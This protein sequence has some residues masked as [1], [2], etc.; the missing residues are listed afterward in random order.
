MTMVHEGSVT[1]CVLA[2]STALIA[3]F[4]GPLRDKLRMIGGQSEEWNDDGSEYAPMY[5]DHADA[6]SGATAECLVCL[7]EAECGGGRCPAFSCHGPSASPSDV[8]VSPCTV[9]RAL[10]LLEDMLPADAPPDSPEFLGPGVSLA[11]TAEHKTVQ[12]VLHAR[13]LQDLLASGDNRCPACRHN[14][15]SDAPDTSHEWGR[16]LREDSHYAFGRDD[17]G[18]DG[19]A[20]ESDESGRDGAAVGPVVGLRPDERVERVEP[21]ERIYTRELR[22]THN[23]GA[24]KNLAARPEWRS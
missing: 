3:L 1:T 4:R 18:R 23:R 7:E 24:Q 21:W 11:C 22:R 6:E 20:A 2:F 13:C 5:A 19:D 10:S 15:I 16:F 9:E 12:H 14:I 8:S 17:S